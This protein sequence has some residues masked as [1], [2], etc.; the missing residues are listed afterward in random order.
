MTLN[1]QLDLLQFSPDISQELTVNL[2]TGLAF[3]SEIEILCPSGIDWLAVAV[4]SCQ[5]YEAHSLKQ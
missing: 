4:I 5:D 2:L 3:Y 1:V